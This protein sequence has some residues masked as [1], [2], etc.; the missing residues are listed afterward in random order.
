MYRALTR[1]ILFTVIGV[2]A[3]GQAVPSVAQETTNYVYDALGRLRTVTRTGTTPGPVTTSYGYDL[4]GNRTS[5]QTTGSP[6]T[7]GPGGGAGGGGPPGG[8]SI[9]GYGFVVTPLSGYTL[10]FYAN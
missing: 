4:A 2:A 3:L 7:G 9:A 6:N 5:V 8:P 1:Y 10:I